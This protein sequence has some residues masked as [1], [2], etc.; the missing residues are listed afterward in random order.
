MYLQQILFAI[1][2]KTLCEKSSAIIFYGSTLVYDNG[3]RRVK[4]LKNFLVD[5]KNN[6][7]KQLFRKGLSHMTFCSLNLA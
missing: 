5:K 3:T 6:R 1:K 4:E 2:L 7:L